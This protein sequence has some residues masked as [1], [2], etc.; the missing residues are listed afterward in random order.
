MTFEDATRKALTK[1]NIP[2]PIIND[3]ILLADKQK[4]GS[5]DLKIPAGLEDECIQ[6]LIVSYMPY[7]NYN[8]NPK[9]N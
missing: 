3:V 4:P 5:K 2:T 6:Y 7:I 9:N 8:L 1:L